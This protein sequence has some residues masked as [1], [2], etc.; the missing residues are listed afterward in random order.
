MKSL[1]ISVKRFREAYED[2]IRNGEDTVTFK[3]N[4]EFLVS[5]MKYVLEYCKVR[6]LTD[7]DYLYFTPTEAG[8]KEVVKK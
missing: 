8:F 4:C 3:D 1:Q 5:Y 6:N 7:R 2:A